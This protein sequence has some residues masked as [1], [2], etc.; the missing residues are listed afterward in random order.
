MPKITP[1]TNE[2]LALAD[3]A[4]PAGAV[5]ATAWQCDMRQPYRVVF[6]A[7]RTVTDHT[8]EVYTTAIQ[9]TDGSLDDGTEVEPLQVWIYRADD[10]PLNADQARELAEALLDCAKE[11]DRWVTE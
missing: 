2:N 9:L 1:I 3:V 10:N 7:D 5:S 11:I 4:P 6:G 8:V